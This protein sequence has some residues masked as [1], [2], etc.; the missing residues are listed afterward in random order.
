MT[1]GVLISNRNI[2]L[3]VNFFDDINISIDGIDEESCSLIRGKGVFDKVVNAVKLL[4]ERNFNNITLSMVLTKNNECL[5]NEFYELNSKLGTEPMLRCLMLEG[6]AETN[7][8]LLTETKI[9]EGSIPKSKKVSKFRMPACGCMGEAVQ[10][11][12]DEKGNIYP[13]D[14][15]THDEFSLGNITQIENITEWIKSINYLKEEALKDYDPYND[16]VISK[17]AD[18]P[19]KVFCWKCP[20]SLYK[21]SK[22]KIALEE[23]CSTYRNFLMDTIWGEEG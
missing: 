13:C 11:T 4:K 5:V 22:N 20:Y 10:L 6:R 14:L 1:N 8:K 2:E 21:C 15:F 9:Q 7:E 18:C 12:I 3:L 16:V 23:H 17:C 19:V